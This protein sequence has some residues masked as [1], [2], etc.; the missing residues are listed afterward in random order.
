MNYFLC[1]MLYSHETLKK[2]SIAKLFPVG[3]D[4]CQQNP[5]KKQK[6]TVHFIIVSPY[7]EMLPYVPANVRE[8][9]ATLPLH[10]IAC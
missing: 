10:Q 6:R 1:Q 2:E 7:F 8:F 4:C 9:L 5:Q 3:T